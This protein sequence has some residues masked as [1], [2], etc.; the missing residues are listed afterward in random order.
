MRYCLFLL[1]LLA[2]NF[3][4][5][6]LKIAAIDNNQSSDRDGFNNPSSLIGCSTS[7]P[8]KPEQKGKT[9]RGNSKA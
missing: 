3:G 6:N 4:L 5:S 7:E 1:T 2:V 8:E 9:N